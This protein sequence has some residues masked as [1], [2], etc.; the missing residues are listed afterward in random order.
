MR[1]FYYAYRALK[2]RGSRASAQLVGRKALS[3]IVSTPD[4]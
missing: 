4:P 2:A 1:S 3:R